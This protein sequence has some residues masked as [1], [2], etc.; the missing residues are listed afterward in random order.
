MTGRPHR[1]RDGAARG[2]RRRSRTIS[3]WATAICVLLVCLVVIAL[4]RPLPRGAVRRHP[5]ADRRGRR[6]SAWPSCSSATSTPRPRSWARSSS[7][8][9]STSRSSSWRAT[10]R[11]GARARPREAAPIALSATI[12]PTAVAALGAAVAYASLIVTRFRGFSQFGD[13][14]RHRHGGGLGGDGDGAAGAVGDASI[15]A[16]A[17]DAPLRAAGDRR[18]S[19]AG[20][21]RRHAARRGRC[22][23]VF[24]A[25]HA[26]SSVIPLE[27]YLHDPFEYD[28]R[29]L[30]NRRSLESG[31]AAL[32]AARRPHL[33][34]HAH[35]GGDRRR[36]AR[37]HRRDPHAR[38]SSATRRCRARR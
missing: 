24:A 5:G 30:R 28:F 8:T 35:A 21:A 13:H 23:G 2:A 17:T 3:S 38:S 32:A 10:K 11:S 6:R 33:R 22:L 25:A 37:A 12:R 26:W 15:S 36:P 14:R 19:D 20:G 31:A 29:N 7:A 4:L 16:S 9:A 27:R 34:P 18:F 1:R